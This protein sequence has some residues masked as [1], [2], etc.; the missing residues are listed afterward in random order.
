MYRQRAQLSSPAP[1]CFDRGKVSFSSRRAREV[2]HRAV[3]RSSVH[4]R[5][6]RALTVSLSLSLSL[7]LSL[8]LS[9]SLAYPRAQGGNPGSQEGGTPGGDP[10]HALVADDP[11]HLGILGS[12]EPPGSSGQGDSGPDH[13]AQSGGPRQPEGVSTGG[14]P[15]GHAHTSAQAQDGHAPLGLECDQAS[16]SRNGQKG[17]RGGGPRDVRSWLGLRPAASVPGGPKGSTAQ[18]E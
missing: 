17:E 11:N 1:H 18:S 7:P 14:N 6:Q 10:Q 8:S 13:E 3:P 4:Q 9:L 15:G 5:K 16:P 2:C 12:P